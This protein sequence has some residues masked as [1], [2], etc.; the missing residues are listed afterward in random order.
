MTTWK[1]KWPHSPVHVTDHNTRDA[2]AEF[3]TEN[4]W[5]CSLPTSCTGVVAAYKVKF[6]VKLILARGDSVQKTQLIKCDDNTRWK[7]RAANKTLDIVLKMLQSDLEERCNTATVHWVVV[8]EAEALRGHLRWKKP[9]GFDG[10][11]MSMLAWFLW[12]IWI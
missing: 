2:S 6:K 11:A 1:I 10:A 9:D 4:Q 12:N 8:E 5:C 3:G 7:H